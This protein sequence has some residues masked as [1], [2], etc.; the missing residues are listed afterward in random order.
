MF[1]AHIA[2]FSAAEYRKTVS[3]R[4]PVRDIEGGQYEVTVGGDVIGKIQLF[5]RQHTAVCRGDEGALVT[6]VSG[7]IR[8]HRG[9]GVEVFS[10]FP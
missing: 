3:K 9:E 7:R 6:L 10:V 1:L 4:T 2:D 5:L 8:V